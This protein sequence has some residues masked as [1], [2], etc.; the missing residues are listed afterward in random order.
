MGVKIGV[1]V[2]MQKLFFYVCIIYLD[3]SIAFSD[4]TR[5][6]VCPEDRILLKIEDFLALRGRFYIMP[7]Q[8]LNFELF[9]KKC[10]FLIIRPLIHHLRGVQAG[11]DDRPKI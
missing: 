6:V 10:F 3:P 1:G 8:T 9:F 5:D 7:G 4:G 2:K 11:F